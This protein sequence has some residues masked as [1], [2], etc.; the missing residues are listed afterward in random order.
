VH[1]IESCPAFQHEQAAA[2]EPEADHEAVSSA[3]WPD[4]VEMPAAVASPVR[5]TSSADGVVSVTLSAQEAAML[6]LLRA[7]NREERDDGLR[8]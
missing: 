8:I 6:S 3:S 5:P 1:E 2:L 4:V 7:L